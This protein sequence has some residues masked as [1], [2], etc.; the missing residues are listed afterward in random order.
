MGHQSRFKERSLAVPGEIK[1]LAGNGDVSRSKILAQGT[2][3]ANAED[4]R[5]PETLKGIDIGPVIYLGGRNG[6]TD[7]M[8]GKERHLFP[9]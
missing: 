8:P 4:A 5:D 1:D 7:A 6:M 3:G 2:A 9:G